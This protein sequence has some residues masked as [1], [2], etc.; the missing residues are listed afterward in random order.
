MN[1]NE[2]RRPRRLRLVASLT[3]TLGLL[4]G[5]LLFAEHDASARTVPS[6]ASLLGTQAALTAPQAA[7]ATPQQLL[8]ATAT[9]A[10]A[11]VFGQQTANQAVAAVQALQV[12]P[13]ADG[14]I[15]AAL[16]AQRA[17]V[18]Q[19]FAILIAQFPAL[20]AQLIVQRTAALAV[21]DAQLAAFG[22]PVPSGTATV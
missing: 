8:P 19:N 13:A 4:S 2:V 21:I 1:D 14:V 17:A 10:Q 18:V 3:A 5:V 11:L 12:D 6:L 15:C 20:S 7:I 22:C 9:D 16:L